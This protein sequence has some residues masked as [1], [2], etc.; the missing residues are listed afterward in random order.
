[1]LAKRLNSFLFIGLSIGALLLFATLCAREH[2]IWFLLFGLAVSIHHIFLLLTWNKIFEKKQRKQTSRLL[3]AAF[4]QVILL[5]ALMAVFLLYT[6][7]PPLFLT[8]IY[9]FQLIFFVIS[10]KH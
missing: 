6:P 3:G 2:L 7:V 10:I 4:L 1:M 8:I 5:C 9:T